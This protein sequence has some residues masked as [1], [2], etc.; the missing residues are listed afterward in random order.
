MSENT[1]PEVKEIPKPVPTTF[2]AK[3][4]E[5]KQSGTSNQKAVISSL[6][7]YIA[8]MNP[9]MVVTE[10]NGAKQQYNLFKAIHNVL[11]NS[12]PDEFKKTWNI[13]L[14]FFNEYKNTVFSDRYIYR[15]SEYWQWSED[16]LTAFQR[17]INIIKLTCEPSTRTAGLRHVDLDRSLAVGISD[18]ARQKVTNFYK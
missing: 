7:T 16:H 15:F 6:E 11:E 18:N 8:T 13:I 5:L 1:T 4:A 10:D 9:S 12:P 17:L 14:A 2:Q 3:I